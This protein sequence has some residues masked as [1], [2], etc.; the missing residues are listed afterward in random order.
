ML[1]DKQKNSFKNTIAALKESLLYFFL[2]LTVVGLTFVFIVNPIF[3]SLFGHCAYGSSGWCNLF[4]EVQ[5]YVA[6]ILSG[7]AAWCFWQ[8]KDER[9]IFKPKYH[10]FFEYEFQI[11]H[12][13]GTILGSDRLVLEHKNF[14]LLRL[15]VC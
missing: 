9:P 1:M 14:P 2:P 12:T 15:W 8:W 7:G 11:L 10:I 6:F 5:M 13:D 4:E 3:R